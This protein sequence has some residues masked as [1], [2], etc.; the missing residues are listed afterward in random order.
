VL[1]EISCCFSPVE[2]TGRGGRVG[3][4]DKAIGQFEGLSESLDSKVTGDPIPV[5]VFLSWLLF[6]LL[7]CSLILVE[8]KRQRTFLC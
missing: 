4:G 5:L 7:L 1:G 6:S 8:R 2:S 3:W